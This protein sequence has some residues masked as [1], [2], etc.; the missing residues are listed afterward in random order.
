[1][2]FLSYKLLWPGQ[3]VIMTWLT[4]YD[5]DWSAIT[6]WLSCQSYPKFVKSIDFWCNATVHHISSLKKIKAPIKLLRIDWWRELCQKVGIITFRWWGGGRIILKLAPL[7]TVW[8]QDFITYNLS[9][10]SLRVFELIYFY[11]F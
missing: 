10:S 8:F 5:G 9:P 7:F 11:V 6:L 2:L 1:M 4:L 3:K